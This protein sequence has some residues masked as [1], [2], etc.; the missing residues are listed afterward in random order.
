M[1]I[2]LD[3]DPPRTTAQQKGEAVING[4]IHHYTKPKVREAE[5]E[6]ALYLSRQAPDYPMSGPIIVVVV[7]VYSR[8]CKPKGGFKTSRPD[9]DNAQKLLLDAMTKC[10]YWDDD[11]AVSVLGGV[12]LWEGP[13]NGIFEKRGIYILATETTDSIMAI[14]HGLWMGD[15]RR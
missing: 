3:I 10:G 11:A 5:N 1:T 2:Y 15:G 9:V 12:K 13:E 4:H 14:L 6:M 8:R 7:W